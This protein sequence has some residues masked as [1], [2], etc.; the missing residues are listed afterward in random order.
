LEKEYRMAVSWVAF[1]L[2]PETPQEGLSLQDLFRGRGVDIGQ[3]MAHLKGI[4]K[5][6][7]LPFGERTMTYNSR[8]AQEL[9]KWAESRGKGREFHSAVFRAYFAHGRNIGERSILLD[10]AV[11]IGLSGDEAE[12][13]LTHR[14]HKD[15]VDRDWSR[16]RDMGVTAVPTFL[17]RGR[18]MV[19]AQPYQALAQFIRDAG[20]MKRGELHF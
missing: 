8:L 15:D 3:M 10:L 1:P 20:V 13:V 17:L 4:A 19:G 9:G 7:G 12:E 6:E 2:H 18:R 16:S 14:T 5:E 11:S